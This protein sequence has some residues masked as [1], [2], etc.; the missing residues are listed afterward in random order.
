MIG[1]LGEENIQWSFPG[2]FLL[3]EEKV[4]AIRRQEGGEPRYSLRGRW[5]G[6]SRGGDG[7]ILPRRVRRVGILRRRNAIHKILKFRHVVPS[8]VRKRVREN[9]GDDAVYFRNRARDLL[10]HSLVLATLSRLHGA[11]IS[12]FA[13]VSS[14]PLLADDADLGIRI[15]RRSRECSAT[16]RGA[17][18]FHLHPETRSR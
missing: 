12:I 6:S 7:A 3:T 16:R 9:V 2:D 14:S 17:G 18:M 4:G 15:A 1:C 10:A 8:P 11:Y 13:V 5:D